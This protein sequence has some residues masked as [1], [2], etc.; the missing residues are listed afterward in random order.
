MLSSNVRGQCAREKP[1]GGCVNAPGQ[2]CRGRV[3]RADRTPEADNAIRQFER[4]ID[5][6][7]AGLHLCLRQASRAVWIT[8]IP[9]IGGYHHTCPCDKPLLGPIDGVCYHN[10]KSDRWDKDRAPPEWKGNWSCARGCA[11]WNDGQGRICD[12]KM[13]RISGCKARLLGAE[14]VNCLKG[15]CVGMGG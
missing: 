1:L 10:W 9:G 8:S 5:A 7:E 11:K 4:D 13:L 6:Y 12:C 14:E 2:K 15:W 3:A